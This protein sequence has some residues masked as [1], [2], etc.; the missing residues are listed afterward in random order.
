MRSDHAT[1]K[2]GSSVGHSTVVGTARRSSGAGARS[3]SAVASVP[4]PARYHP[5]LAAKAP[6]R[7]L[8]AARARPAVQEDHRRPAAL[9]VVGEPEAVDG[10]PTRHGG[11]DI[12][13]DRARR[14]DLPRARRPRCLAAGGPAAPGGCRGRAGS[15]ARRSAEPLVLRRGRAPPHVDR[16]S[17]ALAGAVAGLGRQ[18]RDVG[19]D[20]RR[21]TRRLL[22]ADA[23]RRTAS[24]WPTSACCP[25]SRGTASAATCSPTRCVVASS[26]APRVWLHTC[27]LDGAAALPNYRARGLRPFRTQTL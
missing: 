15:P 20:G 8:V 6:G 13:G 4:A 23:T 27:T 25:T 24:R 10:S 1:G 26:S 22:R 7:A 5:M 16:P 9:A 12:P 3:A 14:A 18:G 2:S 11:Q 21:R 17:R 19:G